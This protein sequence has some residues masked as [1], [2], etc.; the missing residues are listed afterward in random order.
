MRHEL[1]QEDVTHEGQPAQPDA[2]AASQT[3]SQQHMG[4]TEDDMTPIT[5]P[6]Q[7]PGDL[8][9]EKGRADDQTTI[10]PETEL[11]PG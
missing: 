6:M 2:N 4:A 7:G 5:T 3:D 11:T 8:V 9:G 10:D 1:D